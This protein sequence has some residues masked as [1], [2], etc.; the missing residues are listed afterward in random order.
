MDYPVAIIGGGPVG[1][2]AASRLHEEGLPFHLFE[3]GDVVAPA[4]RGWGHVR[5]FSPWRYLID[6]SARRLLDAEGWVEPDPDEI[7][8]GHEV[9]AR[10]L[11]PLARAS[12]LAEHIHLGTRVAAVS[13][14]GL[15]RVKSPG[16]A[17]RP[18]V[19]DVID[20]D[21]RRRQLLARAVIDASGTWHQP[22]PLGSTGYWAEGERELA[23]RIHY[24][25]P[26]VAGAHRNRYAGRR[27]AVV[28]SGHSA[29]HVLL[30]L[31]RLS[32]EGT[33][34]TWLLRAGGPAFGGEGADALTERGRLG[35]RAR[36]LTEAGGVQV[37]TGFA[38]RRVVP[39]SDGVT[40]EAFDGARSPVVDEVVVATGYRPDPW[41]TRELRLDLDPVVEAP[42]RLA[43]L[44][45]P[46]LHSCGTVPP[47][48]YR[49]LTHPERDF[50]TVGMKSYGR[51][52]TFLLVTGYE[53]VRSVVKA[54]AGDLEAAGRVELD[55]PETGVCNVPDPGA[56][57]A[58]VAT[59]AVGAGAVRS[60]GAGS[61]DG[62]G[63]CCG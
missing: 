37:V 42:A 17:E 8:L 49:E 11:E 2:A 15:D 4:V 36:A 24:G 3:Q 22:N 34:V 30:D 28:G 52:P 43:P 33:E 16:R 58:A 51:A 57:L 12:A 47:H 20:A 31:A 18:F 39:A 40:L 54:I 7:P 6:D 41:I 59:A 61:A 13:R 35:Q 56:A 45:D 63:G 5:L 27:V 53:Q 46:N 1:L 9:V 32:E 21:G 10:Y 26:D 25:I 29:F 23:D 14:A 44:I 62:Q 60:A 55:L 50:Y 38:T 19:L 48:G